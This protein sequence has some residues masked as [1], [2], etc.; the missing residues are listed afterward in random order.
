MENMVS[1]QQI[2]SQQRLEIYNMGKEF[3][4]EGLDENYFKANNNEELEIFR[5]GFQEGIRIQTQ[6]METFQ[7]HSIKGLR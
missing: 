2:S 5:Q 6:N 3:A 7:E 1:S 4:F